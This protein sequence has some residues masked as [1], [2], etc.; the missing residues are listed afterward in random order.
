M[1]ISSR[2]TDR[3]WLAMAPIVLAIAAG[4]GAKEV[5]IP[6][7]NNYRLAVTFG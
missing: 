1:R 3:R 5:A 7:W 6:W 4:V 2:W